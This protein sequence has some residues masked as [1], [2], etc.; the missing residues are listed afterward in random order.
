MNSI[1]ESRGVKGGRARM[2]AMAQVDETALEWLKLSRQP[3]GKRDAARFETL[4]KDPLVRFSLIDS[5]AN[6]LCPA[7]K[8][9]DTGVG[10][11]SMREAV[12][13]MGGY[14][15]TEDCPGFLGHKWMDCQLEAT[16][17]GPE[18]VQRRQLSMTM[19]SPVFLEQLKGWREDLS[20]LGKKRPDTGALLTASGL[21]LWLWT[22]RHLQTAVDADGAKLYHSNRQGVTFSLADSLCWLLASRC[23]IKDVM[24]LEYMGP[25]SPTVAEGLAGTVAFLMDLCHVQAARAA[26]ES[27]RICAELVFGYNRPEDGGK[28]GALEDFLSLRRNIDTCLAG[29]RL[30]KDRAGEALTK[31]MIPEA[32]DYPL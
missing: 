20:A 21:E 3:E 11:D 27:S 5:M 30:A 28:G 9:W 32:L 10:A 18:A 23:Q 29:S 24:E 19:T 22:Y 26:G 17:E 4:S 12:S 13:M 6:V 1:L 16:Y 31:V 7:T 25:G 8:L 14:G 15:I 2:K